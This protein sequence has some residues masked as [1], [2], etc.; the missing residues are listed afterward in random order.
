LRCAE[1]G[2]QEKGGELRKE[3]KWKEKGGKL[4]KD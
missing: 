2:M 4:E 1:F 3:W